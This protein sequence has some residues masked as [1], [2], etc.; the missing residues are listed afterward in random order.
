MTCGSL[1]LGSL[2]VAEVLPHRSNGVVRALGKQRW[3]ANLAALRAYRAKHGH[4]DVPTV[5]RTADGIALGSVL[6]DWRHKHRRGQL[7]ADRVAALE[8]LGVDWSPNERVWVDFLAACDR[9]V[10]EYGH[11]R[12]RV[13]Y[14]DDEEFKLGAKMTHYRKVARKG[15]L[16]PQRRAALDARGMIWEPRAAY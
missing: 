15:E 11:L 2:D 6:A 7:A 3:E 5:Y 12:V 14:V 4:V 10:R 16:P 13:D 8:G 9:Y 1:L